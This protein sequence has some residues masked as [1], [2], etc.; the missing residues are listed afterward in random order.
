MKT[1]MFSLWFFF[2]KKKKTTM[3]KKTQKKTKVLWFF[4]QTLMVFIDV[5]INENLAT[6]H[7]TEI[8]FIIIVII[9]KKT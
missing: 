3:K 6:P 2:S 5:S 7:V 8:F 4:F 1:L 9:S